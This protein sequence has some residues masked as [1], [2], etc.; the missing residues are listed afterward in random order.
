MTIYLFN[1]ARIS[2]SAAVFAGIP[3]LARLMQVG[4]GLNL[5]I[6]LL[7]LYNLGEGGEDGSMDY[8]SCSA[9]API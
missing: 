3:E 6:E 1:C 8:R 2:S 7:C 4:D 5:L 9:D